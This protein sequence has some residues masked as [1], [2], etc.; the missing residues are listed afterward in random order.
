ML[1][2]THITWL[3]AS[4]AAVLAGLIWPSALRGEG[5]LVEGFEDLAGVK[6][7]TGAPDQPVVVTGVKEPSY[8]TQ[9]AQ[10]GLIQPGTTVSFAV[11]ARAIAGAKWFR[12]DT[13]AIQALP[14]PVE[15]HVKGTEFSAVIPAYVQAGSDTLALPLPIVPARAQA[16]WPEGDVVI[17]LKNLGQT[18][19][20]VDNARLEPATPAPQDAVLLDFGP[21]GQV[22]WPGFTAG[23]ASNDPIAWGSQKK[24]RAMHARWPDPLG[25][26]FAGPKLS[27]NAVDSLTLGSG[28]KSVSAW[29][30]LTHYGPGLKQP[31]G[32]VAMFSRRALMRAQLERREMLG[33]QGLLE[34]A[35]GAWTPKWFAQEY[36]AQLVRLVPVTAGGT[37]RRIDLE[38]CQLAGAAMVPL[39][40]RSAMADYVKMIQSDLERYRRQFVV[41]STRP[42]R[43]ATAPEAEETRAGAMVFTPPPGQALAARWVPGA[44]DRTGS[45][46][47]TAGA[48]MDVV[49]TLA[50]VPLRAAAGFNVSLRARTLTG[51]T[52]T[53][54]K[55]GG[56]AAYGVQRVA[57]VVSAGVDFQ[58]WVLVPSARFNAKPGDVCMIVLKGRIAPTTQPGRYLGALTIAGPGLKTEV[59][60][61]ID[62]LALT[63][64]SSA[65]P[66]IGVRSSV[67]AE[68]FYGALAQTLSPEMGAQETA[69]ARRILLTS[70][71][72]ALTL[73]GTSVSSGGG[74]SS[75]TCMLQLKGLPPD[76]TTRGRMVIDLSSAGGDL[77][78]AVTST[79][80]LTTRAGV[81]D[82]YLLWTSVDDV[83]TKDKSAGTALAGADRGALTMMAIKASVL[84]DAIALDTTTLEPWSALLVRPDVQGLD[85]DIAAVRKAGVKDVYLD[86]AYPNRYSCGFYSYAVGASGSYVYGA[87]FTNGGAYGGRS[88]DGRGMLAVQSDGTLTPTVALVSLWEARGD[89]QLMKSCEALLQKQ[90][91]ASQG[92]AAMAAVLEK[93]KTAVAA[94]ALPPT[95]SQVELR[96]TTVSVATLEAWR[97]ELFAAAADMLKE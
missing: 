51:R 39:T 75:S 19:L 85:K 76:V 38:N 93:I 97:A 95:F 57:R 86:V 50:I 90:G 96:E 24:R 32:Y 89:Y 61:V 36:S 8:V 88:M 1:A 72:D 49:T 2:R 80:A 18:A 43:C 53:F 68:D 10:A 16:R 21:K 17:S 52:L 25:G 4:F 34:G 14:Q 13:A 74:L 3:G 12:I 46:K 33:P 94:N 65:E 69:N 20:V 45:V 9:G 67:R 77:D 82:P 87:P 55:P 47:I 81:K 5:T 83:A 71:V 56:L 27:A 48:G 62:V 6:A 84:R 42:I 28:T 35:A 37:R 11:T 29:L 44:S 40:G 22:I 31:T 59:P 73:D 7:V 91:P 64:D 23:G 66:V 58:P 60:L 63:G 54:A 30:W 41:G 15:I 26:D 78:S 79:L 92:G 70:G